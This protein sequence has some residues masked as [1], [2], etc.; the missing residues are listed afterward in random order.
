MV[1]KTQQLC[2]KMETEQNIQYSGY[3]FTTGSAA[4]K[5]PMKHT[6]P[7]TSLPRRQLQAHTP[8]RRASA[9]N[10][11]DV[12]TPGCPAVELVPPGRPRLPLPP[13]KAPRPQRHRRLPWSGGRATATFPLPGAVPGP[14]QE[15]G[16]RRRHRSVFPGP[17]KVR[18]CSRVPR[19]EVGVWMRQ[20]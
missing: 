3:S 8:L 17:G 11:P 18:G 4:F 5:T 13:L 1:F 10:P 16:R 6:C 7:P 15:L 9:M 20:N 14:E 19:R 2:L 12:N